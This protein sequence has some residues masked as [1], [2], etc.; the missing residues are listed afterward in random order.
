L[1]YL[2]NPVSPVLLIIGKVSHIH[3]GC[4]WDRI[5]ASSEVPVGVHSL[6]VADVGR[7]GRAAVTPVGNLAASPSPGMVA[8][9]GVFRSE[10]VAARECSLVG[11]EEQ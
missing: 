8:A 10:V 1:G 2:Y 11:P 7:R 3:C 9:V 5:V 4:G 6:Q